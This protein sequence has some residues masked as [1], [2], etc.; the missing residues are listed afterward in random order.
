MYYN[1]FSKITDADILGLM[2]NNVIEQKTLEYKRQ[3]PDKSNENEKIKILQ[4]ISSFANSEGGLIIF[5][6]KENENGEASELI[7]IETQ[8]DEDFQ[9]FQNMIKDRIVP[10]ITPPELKA[11][12]VNEKKIYLMMIFPS[13]SKPHFVKDNC[14][15][16]GRNSNGKYM[17]DVGDIR[18]LFFQ[19]KNAEEQFENFKMQRIMKLKS[20]NFPFKYDS[21]NII[22]LHIASLS[23]I[24]NNI[25]LSMSN[26]ERSLG[27]FFPMV[28]NGYDGK[29][30]YDGCLN[31]CY[32]GDKKMY[33][34]VQIFRNGIIESTIF[35]F[36]N[37]GNKNFING[38]QVEMSVKN[39]ITNY[40]IELKKLNIDFPFFVSLSLLNTKGCIIALSEMYY[41]SFYN[42]S[43]PI[44]EEDLLLPT[45]YIDNE[46]ELE[47]K[48]WDCF[49]VFWNT[50]GRAGSP[51]RP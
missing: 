39:A 9:R 3:L 40:I 49:D 29:N 43:T 41:K 48:V 36:F 32:T 23:S 11:L 45:I 31:S 13:F 22:S 16:Y 7:N 5:G 25:Q 24:N 34:Y 4:C 27:V 28:N 10:R 12:I 21:Q 33:S 37:S 46:N 50:S 1:D 18:N 6:M 38:T 2:N 51:N 20:G 42:S 26:C 30:N 15:F 35:D 14:V 17:L 8:T 47:K 19:S 44:Y